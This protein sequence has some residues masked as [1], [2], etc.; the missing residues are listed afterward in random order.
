MKTNKNIQNNR[1]AGSISRPVDVLYR[2]FM[3]DYLRQADH[4]NISD[5]H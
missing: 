3:R 1:L 5:A 2:D 4:V